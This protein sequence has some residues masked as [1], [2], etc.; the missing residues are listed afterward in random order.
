M[1]FC[2]FVCHR[3]QLKGTLLDLSFF[4]LYLK[5]FMISI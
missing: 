4:N 5:K 3:A 1:C 2:V